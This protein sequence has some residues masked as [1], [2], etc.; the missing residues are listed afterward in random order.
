MTSISEMW[1]ELVEVGISS[2]SLNC[3]SVYLPGG[4]SFCVSFSIGAWGSWQGILRQTKAI[5]V[6]LGGL[7]DLIVQVGRVVIID[8]QF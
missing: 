5:S 4:D 7:L 2:A 8:N 6:I 3:Y 1:S